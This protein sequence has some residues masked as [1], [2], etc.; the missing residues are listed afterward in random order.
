[1]VCLIWLLVGQQQ[2]IT[3]CLRQFQNCTSFNAKLSQVQV[4]NVTRSRT[5]WLCVARTLLACQYFNKP[6]VT[7]VA[8]I[9]SVGL[10]FSFQ[11]IIGGAFYENKQS[12]LLHQHASQTRLCTPRLQVSPHDCAESRSLAS[13]VS[14]HTILNISNN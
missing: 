14:I 1:M 8:F 12:F 7:I 6:K 13:R 2:E 9:Y 3:R 5:A 10:A 4:G 11:Q